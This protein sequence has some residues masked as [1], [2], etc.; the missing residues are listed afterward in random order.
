MSESGLSVRA[1]LR[2]NATFAVDVDTHFPAGAISA[3]FGASGAGKTTLLRIIAGLQ[4]CT[5]AQIT[6]NGMTWQ[7]AT[8]C[9]PV[10]RRP[11]GFVA[12][13]S[14]LL[15]H[16]TVHGNLAYVARRR[17][18]IDDIDALVRQFDL[19]T[20]LGRRVDQLSGG[21]RQR[22]A[23]ACALTG[24]PDVLLLD[25]PLSALDE[26]RRRELLPYLN[27]LKEQ[28]KLTTIFVT[29]RIDDVT[30]IADQV[31][32]MDSGRISQQGDLVDLQPTEGTHL[33]LEEGLGT[34]LDCEVVAHDDRWV[35][36][37][38]QCGGETVQL[39]G[40][41]SSLGARMRIQVL[42]RDVSISLTNES[43]SSIVNRLPATVVEIHNNDSGRCRVVLQLDG[44][45][46]QA[47]VS[48]WSVDQLQLSEGRRV[49]AQIKSVAIIR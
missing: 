32:V 49:Y 10:H 22:V 40:I 19:D 4:P 34:V 48:V 26:R 6:S 35:C 41:S 15:P 23:L 30:Q 36:T 33:L 18:G 45:R 28:T 7:M 46:L 39:V 44:F 13:H 8:Q 2:L 1:A 25:E 38:V 29:H 20:L 21:E 12:Q 16:L 27:L 47:L 31:F 37:S 11:L 9:L 17:A 5:A 14:S 3:L 43:Q 24:S 42:A